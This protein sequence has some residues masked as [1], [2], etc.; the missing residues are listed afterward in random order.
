MFGIDLEDEAY[1]VA[2]YV[3]LWQGGAP[4]MSIWDGHTGF[5]LMM[6]FFFLYHAVVP[7]LDGIVLFSRVVSVL[8]FTGMA[9]ALV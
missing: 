2:T 8:L 1:W 4:L 5:F 9:L 7:P 3:Q 6:P